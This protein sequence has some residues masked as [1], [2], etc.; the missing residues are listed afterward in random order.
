MFITDNAFRDPADSHGHSV[1]C[2]PF[3]LYDIVC[4]V[5]YIPVDFLHGFHVIIIPSQFAK[6]VDINSRHICPAPYSQFTVPMLSDNKRMDAS[7]VHLQMLAEQIPEPGRI[8]HRAAADN[9]LL[10]IAGYFE[11]RIGKDIH[12]IGHNH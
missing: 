1:I 7:A 10:G 5:T 9:P 4:A 8:K 3:P 2:S 11:R 12:G 6:A